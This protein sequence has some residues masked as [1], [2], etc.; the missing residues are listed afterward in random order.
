[1]D[2]AERV[3]QPTRPYQLHPATAGLFADGAPRCA[4]AGGTFTRLNPTTDMTASV[5]AAGRAGDADDLTLIAASRFAE[6][7]ACP[8]ADRAAVL[9]RAA[10]L[11][12]QYAD[13]FAASMTA[14]TGATAD[15][16]AFN[17][18]I[19]ADML[20]VTASMAEA[21]PETPANVVRVPAGVCVAIAPWNAPVALGMRAIAFP[22]AFGNSVVFK[23]SELCP[24]THVL[25]GHLLHDAG[26]PPG[27]LNII[28]NAP[29][30]AEEVVEALIAN[31]AV[32]RVNFTGST[33]VGRIVAGIGARHLKRCLLELGGKSPFIVLA[34]ADIPRA[35]DAA[36]HGAYLNAGQICMAT[37]RIIV[38]HRIADAFVAALVDRA[39]LLTAG[40]PR[41]P[42]TRVGPL[43]TPAIAARLSALIDDATAKG[44]TLRAGGPARGQ[45]MDATVVDNVSP[46]MRIYHEE[47][48]GPI[49]GIYRT[50]S[51]DEAITIANDSA[52]GLSS[53]VW[54]RDKAA[55]RA[56]ADRLDSGICHINGA[57]VA[58][59]PTMPF[60][61]IKDSG[62]G[63]FGGTACLDEFTELRWITTQD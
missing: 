49:V 9:R 28:T 48:F 11:I 52:Y 55:A 32:R 51:V 58:D 16:V 46:M 15:W 21:T 31:P 1:M 4:A 44:A 63:R 35:V 38:D 47:C 37:D 23:A 39:T 20:R 27:V 45:F 14:E 22:L 19:A 26:L 33:R 6:W 60:G 43:A 24:V 18:T 13:R 12:P 3:G 7:A 34:D 41:L 50:G 36:T 61:G 30:H 56:V 42:V 25:L 2:D 8:G 17:L 57:T 59:D 54:G 53:A 40:D 62:Y 10:A 29:E 5:A